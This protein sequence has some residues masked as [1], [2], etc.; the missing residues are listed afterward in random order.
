MKTY[1]R[2]HIYG[3]WK[4]AR[5]GK[6]VYLYF[7]KG[8]KMKIK[9]NGEM[10]SHFRKE[11]WKYFENLAHGKAMDELDSG[12]AEYDTLSRILPIVAKYGKKK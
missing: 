3:L 11:D 2:P 4:I 5:R 6:Y 1:T 12:L 8:P 7:D 10:R 9:L